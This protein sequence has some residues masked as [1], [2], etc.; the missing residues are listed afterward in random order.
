[1]IGSILSDIPQL[2]GA[3]TG[4]I[5]N[6]ISG[7]SLMNVTGRFIVDVAGQSGWQLSINLNFRYYLYKEVLI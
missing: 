3:G 2:P 5:K 4:R 7:V 6:L 1:M